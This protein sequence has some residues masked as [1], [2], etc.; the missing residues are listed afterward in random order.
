MRQIQF[1]YAH[2]LSLFILPF[3]KED[4]SQR[5]KEKRKY[6]GGQKEAEITS[7]HP[8]QRDRH[9]VSQDEAN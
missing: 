8:S 2:L 1:D 4:T 3:G 5:E 7:I 6:D 9:C